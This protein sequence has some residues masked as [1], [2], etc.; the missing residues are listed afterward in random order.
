[1]VMDDPREHLIV[2]LDVPTAE[3]ALRLVKLLKGRV[4]YFKVGLQLFT[5]AG[6]AIVEKILENEC[7][8]FLDLKLHDIPNT[9]SGAIGSAIEL[10]VGMLTLHTTGGEVML[11]K[12]AETVASSISQSGRAPKLLGVTILTSMDEKQVSGVGLKVP[13]EDLVLKLARLADNSGL[14][15]IVCSPRELHRLGKEAFHRIFFV[16]P[17]IRPSGS[18]K[19][20]QARTNTPTDAIRLGARHLVVGRPIIKAVDPASAAEMIVSE[21][22]RAKIEAE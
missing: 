6:P 11:R 19:D 2:A 18:Q 5:S 4:G 12:A 20:D 7:Q 3:E 14:D 13:I 1:M 9:V 21:I 17:G 15:G 22:Q 8:V 10:G 16:T